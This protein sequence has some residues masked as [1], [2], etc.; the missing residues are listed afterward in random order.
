MARAAFGRWRQ[1]GARVIPLTLVA[2]THR[3]NRLTM[4]Q[5]IG[6]VPASVND[7][8]VLH[9]MTAFSLKGPAV[10]VPY[11]DHGYEPECCHVSA[12]H[13]ALRH[14]GRRVH[15]WSLVYMPQGL[16]GEFHSI[17]ET[18]DKTWIDV[19]PPRTGGNQVLFIVD[20]TAEIFSIPGG[21][22]LEANR[23]ASQTQ[24]FWI[25]SSPCP[26]QTWG[27]SETTPDF[28]RYCQKIGFSPQDFPT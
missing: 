4:S 8:A 21:F 3:R 22:A 14:G 9:F 13:H 25:G 5:L 10:Y 28:L 16:M 12:K 24:P 20:P 17:W 1:I 2:N 19:T 11:Q 27:L 26:G 7:S 23:L 6:H 15:G 18:P